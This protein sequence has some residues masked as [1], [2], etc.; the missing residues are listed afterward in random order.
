MRPA[1]ERLAERDESVAAAAASASESPG[2]VDEQIRA[3]IRV[4]AR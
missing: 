4:L 1:L 3:A 2:L